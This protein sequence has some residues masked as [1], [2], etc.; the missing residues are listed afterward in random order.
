M[1]LYQSIFCCMSLRCGVRFLVKL[2]V[3][4]LGITGGRRQTSKYNQASSPPFER[5]TVWKHERETVLFQ[6]VHSN[7]G[8]IFLRSGRSGT[9]YQQQTVINTLK[10]GLLLSP[11]HTPCTSQGSVDSL[12]IGTCPTFAS[13]LM[14]SSPN[15]WVTPPRMS[16]LRKGWVRGC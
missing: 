15:R 2:G 13:L 4:L 9:R 12:T 5:E 6:T 16:Y 1:V 11:R 7:P 14:M 10:S 8:I 3:C